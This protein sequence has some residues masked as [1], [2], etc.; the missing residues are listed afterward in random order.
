MGIEGGTVYLS[1]KP[2]NGGGT[3]GM[4]TSEYEEQLERLGIDKMDAPNVVSIYVGRYASQAPAP[5]K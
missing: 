1:L 3:A 2:S 4:P 5:S